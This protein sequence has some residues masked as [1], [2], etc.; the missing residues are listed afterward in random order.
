M[1]MQPR[2]ERPSGHIGLAPHI[3]ESAR[4]PAPTGPCLQLELKQPTISSHVVVG[5]GVQSAL[6]NRGVKQPFARHAMPA[7][8]LVDR[9]NNPL[10]RV[11]LLPLQTETRQRSANQGAKYISSSHDSYSI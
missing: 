11:C 5:P 3:P 6:A 10:L 4:I 9:R 8:G 7:S 2:R 1:G